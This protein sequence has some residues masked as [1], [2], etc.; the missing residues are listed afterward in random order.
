MGADVVV[1]R[2][3]VELEPTLSIAPELERYFGTRTDLISGAYTELALEP[4]PW[5]TLSPGVRFD[6]YQSREAS[7]V[8]GRSQDSR[9]VRSD[10]SACA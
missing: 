8:G 9:A 1:D 6:F 7:A 5:F 3:D 4:E 10:A 2:F